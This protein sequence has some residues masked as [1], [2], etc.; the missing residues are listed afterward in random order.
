MWI[1]KE[2]RFHLSSPRWGDLV[3]LPTTRS[4]QAMKKPNKTQQL[5]DLIQGSP[6]DFVEK[7][8]TN[9]DDSPAIPHSG[10]RALLEGIRRITVASCGRQWG[11]STA[12]GWYIVWWAIT[13]KARKIYIIAP[14]LD[15]SRIIFN[16]VAR[17]FRTSPLSGQLVRKPVDFPFPT[18]KLKNGTEIH[19]RG[20]NSPQYIRGKVSHLT[21][22]DEAAFM[23][24]RT[25]TDV[26]R[27]MMSVTGKTPDAAMILISTPFGEG[28][29]KDLY[30][31]CS[32]Q[33]EAGSERYKHFH[34]PS[35][36]NP[37][38]DH[39]EIESVKKQYGEDSL[40]WRTEYLAEFMDDDMAIIPWK[41]IKWAYE[42]Y[43]YNEDHS[44]QPASD[45]PV[46]PRPRRN[47]A[48][49]ADLANIRDYFVAAVADVT[50]DIA[51]LV[52]MDRYQ[53]RGWAAMKATIRANYER[54]NWADTCIDATTYGASV[55]ED[56]RDIGVE[57]YTFSNK[58]KYE[59]VQEL[60]RVFAEHKLV[61]PYDP[62]I[63]QELRYF[64]YVQ[65]PSKNL[66]MEAKQGHDDIPIAL[67]LIA[68]QIVNRGQI[69]TF[70]DIDISAWGKEMPAPGSDNPFGLTY[71][72]R[73][74]PAPDPYKDLLEVV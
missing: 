64:T 72:G 38:I 59:L 4:T 26:I 9:D 47:Y 14:S 42:H 34:F 12:L 70:R 33:E 1:I 32:K 40:L 43:P 29:F 55:E 39:Q 71:R 73:T 49:G 67:A 11:K 65:T 8:L 54:Y 35:E 58:S 10:Q 52:H 5:L 25:I 66:K 22:C 69:G 53:Q 27:P 7:L 19:G 18:I 63:I 57:G 50:D 24:D 21:I 46:P 51:F 16:E 41:D 30:F 20:A 68:H 15:Q 48:Q 28:A 31:E 36:S 37:H 60:V 2:D 44:D 23:K 56:L 3:V 13:H 61:I 74:E 6:V 17:H 62:T 45:F